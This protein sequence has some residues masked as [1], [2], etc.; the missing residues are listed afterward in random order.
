MDTASPGEPT[1]KTDTQTRTGRIPADT[2]ST[3]LMLARALAG[4]LSIREVADLTGLNREAWRD[5]ERGRR[6]RDIIEVCRRVA[7]K[8]DIDFNWLLLGGPLDGPRGVPTRKTKG[9]SGDTVPYPQRADRPAPTHPNGRPRTG[10]PPSC[11][12]R[13]V[14][15]PTLVAA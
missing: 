13:A 7:E 9:G 14:R 3:R 10:A 15:L 1:A 5:W 4:H 8:L 6:P 2:F 11:P 12:R